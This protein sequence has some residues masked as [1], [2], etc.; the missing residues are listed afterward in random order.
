MPATLQPGRISPERSVPAHIARPEYVGR[1]TP[2]LGEP[3]IKD[4]ET[5]SR[6]RVAGQI[7]A[8]ALAEVGRHVVPGV[9]TDELD[10]IGHEF[11]LDHG[12]DELRLDAV[13]DA[14]APRESD[15]FEWNSFRH[16]RT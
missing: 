3:D 5:I 12:A 2:R 1:R 10:Q 4:A 14:D 11:L 7:A 16:G 8:R 13:L 9:T 15:D 6:M